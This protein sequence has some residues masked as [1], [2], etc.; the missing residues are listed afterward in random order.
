MYSSPD[1]S[2]SIRRLGFLPDMIFYDFFYGLI[3][4]Y[5]FNYMGIFYFTHF[6]SPW[7]WLVG[8]LVGLKGM[9]RKEGCGMWQAET[10]AGEECGGGRWVGRSLVVCV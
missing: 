7:G 8:W 3:M 10:I 9:D 4:L 1:Y 5:C 6:L 2:I